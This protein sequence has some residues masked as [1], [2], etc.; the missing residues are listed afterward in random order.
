MQI[1][2]KARWAM[3][4]PTSMGV[5]L[6]PEDRLPVHSADRFRLFASSAETNV[7]SIPARLGLPVKVLTRFIEGSPISALVRS[8]L[9]AR[10]MDVEGPEIPQGDAWGYRHQFNIADSGFGARAPRVWNDRA[11]EVGRTM[12]VDDFDLARILGDEGVAVVH[13]SGLIASLSPGT[14]ELC[15]EIARRAKAAGS[16]VAFDLNYRASF[17]KGRE[18]ELAEAFHAIASECD[19]LYGNEEDFQL[20]LG[21]EGPEPGGEGL[22]VKIEAFQEMIGRIR[23]A[24]PGAQWIG[25]SLREV[26]SANRHLWGMILWGDEEFTVVKPR[27]IEVFDRIGGGDASVGGMLY[28]LLQGWSAKE[29]AQFGWATGVLATMGPRDDAAPADEAQV[30]GIWNGNARVVR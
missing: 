27:E 6:A 22:D 3:L 2:D 30:W 25:T 11:G 26:I 18:G 8:D 28:G 5:R 23:T 12:S 29:S 15:V 17:W 20:C 9:R 7:A 1:R 14:S 4:V 16:I 21:I 13:L 10:G 19:V 24:Y